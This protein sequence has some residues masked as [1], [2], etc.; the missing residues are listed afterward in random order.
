MSNEDKTSRRQ[1]LGKTAATMAGV[2]LL[3]GAVARQAKAQPIRRANARILGAN[4]RINAGFIGNGMQF[5]VLLDRGFFNR[6]KTKSDIEFAAV[7]DVWQPRLDYAQ[8]RTGA[9]FA[10]RDY[11]EIIA[12]KDIDGV[13]VVV[14]DHWHYQIA[15]EALL[16][17]KDVYLEKPMT[18]T[19]EQ[20]ASLNDLVNRTGR[21][22]QVGGCAR[23]VMRCALCCALCRDGR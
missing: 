7:C 12:R 3:S 23:Q 4:D 21:L 9:A 15:R 17:G 18:Y 5:N 8:K 13:V 2:S 20:A 22:I 6:K 14:P 10:T 1:F 16:A 11:R 19:I